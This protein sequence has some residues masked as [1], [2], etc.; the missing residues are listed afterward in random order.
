MDMDKIK[1]IEELKE[2]PIYAMSL[3]GKELFHSNILAWLLMRKNNNPIK[4][5]FCI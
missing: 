1:L 3:G 5:I 4:K 2:N